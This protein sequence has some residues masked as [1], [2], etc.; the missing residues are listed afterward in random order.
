[1]N[2]RFIKP[3]RDHCKQCRVVYARCDRQL[4]G[5]EAALLEGQPLPHHIVFSPGLRMAIIGPD[6]PAKQSCDFIASDLLKQDY[7]PAICVNP[8][9][10]PQKSK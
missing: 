2:D 5:V 1:L 10:A 3:I 9:P 8:M 6:A 4:T 7:R